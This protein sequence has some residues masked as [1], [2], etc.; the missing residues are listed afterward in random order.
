MKMNVCGWSHKKGDFDGRSYD[1]VVIYCI[2]RM[3]Q[4]DIQRGAAGIDMRGDSSLVEKLRK[5]E[6]TGII[7]CEV[8]TEARATG[9]GQFVETVV[10]I[11]PSLSSKAA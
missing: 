5:I 3:E 1:Y 2:S 9:K 4:K 6:F 11:V 8:E 7:Q 10:N